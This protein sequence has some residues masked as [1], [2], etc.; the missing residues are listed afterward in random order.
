MKL[1]FLFR[2]VKNVVYDKKGNDFFDGKR[3]SWSSSVVPKHF[4]PPSLS[5]SQSQ[6]LTTVLLV[7]VR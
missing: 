5:L 7:T 6:F 3:A 1:M 2:N 4:F